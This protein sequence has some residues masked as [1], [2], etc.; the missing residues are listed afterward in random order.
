[1]EKP[2]GFAVRVFA[3]FV[4]FKAMAE[5]GDLRTEMSLTAAAIEAVAAA[6]ILHKA[7]EYLNRTAK[8]ADAAGVRRKMRHVVGVYLVVYL[9]LV[10]AGALVGA[11]F[12]R[13]LLGGY[14]SDQKVVLFLITMAILA[15]GT[16]VWRLIDWENTEKARKKKVASDGAE[17]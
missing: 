5:V 15:I 11:G 9:A 7:A 2:Y 10:F 17:P 8:K 1:M 12:A 3:L 6:L 13:D 16:A 14:D 4:Y